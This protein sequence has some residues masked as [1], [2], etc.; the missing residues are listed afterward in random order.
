MSQNHLTRT[1]KRN[2]MK[3]V[4]WLLTGLS[5]SGLFINEI[6]SLDEFFSN[7]YI[8]CDKDA[9][10]FSNKIEFSCDL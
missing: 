5:P 1:T 3:S 7:T 8:L 9:F 4:K 2:F 6:F 10:H